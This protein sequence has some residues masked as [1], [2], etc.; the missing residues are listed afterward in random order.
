MLVALSIIAVVST[1]GFM[2]LM[3]ICT[4]DRR[5]ARA[6]A[7]FARRNPHAC[8]GHC[9]YFGPCDTCAPPRIETHDCPV[10]GQT[11]AM[12]EGRIRPGTGGIR[13]HAH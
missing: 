1:A 4:H 12:P 3:A 5:M 7:D 13:T 10:D 11:Y 8:P 9:T 2:V 6:Y